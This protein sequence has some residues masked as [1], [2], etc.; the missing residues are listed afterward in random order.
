MSRDPRGEGKRRALLVGA[1]RSVL[2]EAVDGP[3]SQG[4]FVDALAPQP[5]SLATARLEAWVRADAEL[6]RQWEL[7]R[8]DLSEPLELE[9]E[10]EEVRLGAEAVEA[11]VARVPD[12]VALSAYCWN[13]D[14][15]IELAGALD[16]RLPG[17]T[18]LLG[19][20][21]VEGDPAGLLVDAPAVDGIILGEGE[22]AFAEVLRHR[23]RDLGSIPG[24]VSRQGEQIVDGGPPRCV[25]ELDAIPSPYLEGLVVP[26]VDGAML[27][28]SRGCLH[29]CGYCTWS[30][31]KR[32]RFFSD[33]RIEAEIRWLRHRGHRH[34]TVTDSAINYDTARL[35]GQLEA[36]R[37]ADPEGEL[38]LTYNVRHDALDQD[39]LEL[40]SRLPTHMVLTGV[41]TLSVEAM[42]LVER[43]PAELSQLR[44]RFEA[45]ARAVRPPV[46]SLV[47][48][49]P[50]DSEAAFFET[51]DRLWR[52]TEGPSPVVGTVLVSLLQVYRG[53]SLWA[54]RQELGLRFQERGIPYLLSSPSWPAEALSRVK[55]DL[56]RRMAQTPERLKA[57][58]AIVLMEREGG[59][60]PWLTRRR[61]RALLGWAPGELRG[62]WRLE[63]MGLQRDTGRAAALRFCWRGGGRARALLV[64]RG[65]GLRRPGQSRLFEL[66]L[67]A[68]PGEPVPA[69]VI[70]TL[71]VELLELLLE[72]EER[73]ARA[74]RRRQ[75][76]PEPR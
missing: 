39:Q 9:D 73:L 63:A 6:S 71:G 44:E 52:W 58:E 10:R 26:P 3:A 8:L 22:L 68:L 69:S 5:Y 25:T 56:R 50:G 17:V 47:L 18:I 37:R 43:A 30:A 4:G 61:L 38:A 67:R 14:A 1:F 34:A 21:A 16:R 42:S 72:G 70:A 45:L 31:E 57:A 51:L 49:L 7:E 32:L 41:E 24:V 75:R 40:L 13:V 74:A 46:V 66:E 11:V 76:A 65:A 29:G 36:I 12:L 2:P 64:R 53:S 35:A 15:L 27:E 60:D 23:G 54:R 48:G 28:L 19:G 62:D 33:A 59:L 55:A 20:R